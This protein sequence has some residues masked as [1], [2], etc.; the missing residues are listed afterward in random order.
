[1]NNSSNKKPNIHAGHRDRMRKR[2]EEGGFDNYQPHEA[3]EMLL[4]Y[5]IPQKDT[6][7]IAHDLL[8]HFDNSISNV[9]NASVQELTSVN[10]ISYNTAILIKM[11]PEFMRMYIDDRNAVGEYIKST[12]DAK[13]YFNAKLFGLD[14]EVFLIVYLDN[15]CKII[16]CEVLEKGTVNAAKV[17]LNK[18]LKGVLTKKAASCIVAHNHPKGVPFASTEDFETTKKIITFLDHINVTL[19]DHIIAGESGIIALS[20][21]MYY[22]D[23]FRLE[24][25]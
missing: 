4:Y 19:K 9:F 22:G 20:E 11:I 7:E 6:N 3:L 2:F 21:S 5:C 18:I 24:Q 14:Y 17:D 23:I 8:A 13:K 10:Y 1:M 16:S 25:R 12:E 15:S